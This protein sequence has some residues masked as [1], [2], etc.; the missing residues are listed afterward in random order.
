MKTD[1]AD[2]FEAVIDGRL[3]ELEVQWH[4]NAAVCV[5]MASGGY[6]EKYAT[7][8]E[9]TGLDGVQKNGDIV[10]FHAGTRQGGDC[11]LTDG[12]RVL[13]VTAMAGTLDEAIRK[14]YEGVS[15]IHFKDAHYRKDIGVK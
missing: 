13:G 3:H 1:L 2:I 6:P 14:S 10:V 9:I 7:G 5:V 4:D 15:H 12:G 8:Y 11:Y